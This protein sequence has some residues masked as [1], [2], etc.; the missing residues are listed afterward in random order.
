[1][2]GRHYRDVVYSS[3]FFCYIAC[4]NSFSFL[5]NNFDKSQERP[6]LRTYHRT[7]TARRCRY[8]EEPWD[9]E[10]WRFHENTLHSGFQFGGR[11]NSY[12]KY[13]GKFTGCLRRF[14]LIK[15]F[16]RRPVLNYVRPYLFT[17]DIFSTKLIPIDMNIKSTFRKIIVGLSIK[18]KYFGIIPIGLSEEKLTQVCHDV[19][20]PKKNMLIFCF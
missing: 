4:T 13:V 2:I 11:K 3:F 5:E 14:L 16:L 8:Q 6:S 12:L 1:M 15:Y 17:Y 20:E 7:G 10:P 9:V 19:Y 18:K